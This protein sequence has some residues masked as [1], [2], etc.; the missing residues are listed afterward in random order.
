MANYLE[1]DKKK[2]KL[3]Y[4]QDNKNIQTIDFAYFAV[5]STIIFRIKITEQQLASLRQYHKTVR[6]ILGT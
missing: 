2:Y 3:T 5:Y 1:S 6:R 4:K